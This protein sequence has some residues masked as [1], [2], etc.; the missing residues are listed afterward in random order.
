MVEHHK[1]RG[2]E[3]CE[4]YINLTGKRDTRPSVE[5]LETLESVIEEYIGSIVTESVKY[6]DEAGMFG[7]EYK[8]ERDHVRAEN[9]S[10]LESR[11]SNYAFMDNTSI[12]FGPPPKS[13]GHHFYL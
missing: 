7:V 11:L 9:V 4:L 10:K 2:G 3:D 6:S 5:E 13:D 1:L 12:V 8:L